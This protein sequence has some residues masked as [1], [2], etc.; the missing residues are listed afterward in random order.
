MFFYDL[1]LSPVTV[2]RFVGMGVPSAIDGAPLQGA[3]SLLASHP[4]V[5]ST[6]GYG[7][8]TLSAS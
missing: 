7:A 5:V 1:G 2:L 6:Y 4:Q 3:A 8:E